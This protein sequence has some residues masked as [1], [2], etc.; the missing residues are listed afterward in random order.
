MLTLFTVAGCLTALAVLCILLTFDKN[1]GCGLDC[2]SATLNLAL[3][4]SL[5][6]ILVFPVAGYLLSRLVKFELYRVVAILTAMVLA[7]LLGSGIRYI[8]ELKSRYRDAESAR[9]VVADFDFMYMAIAT[10]N[11]QTYTNA[12]EGESKADGVIPQWQR[13]VIDGAWCDGRHKQ[14]HM[15]CKG[16]VAYVNESDWKAFSLI[17][18]ENLPGARPI[19]SMNL[20]APDNAPD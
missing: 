17:P 10:R 14:A 5:L 12:K 16:G 2:P 18:Q 6:T 9:P 13:C 8:S 4:C 1:P 11:V 19:K 3:L 20:C 7:A 15:R